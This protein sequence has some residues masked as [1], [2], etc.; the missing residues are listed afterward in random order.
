M[1]FNPVGKIGVLPTQLLKGGASTWVA[2]PP[3]PTR[4]LTA[5]EA[6]FLASAP[7]ATVTTSS[8][9]ST[10]AGGSPGAQFGPPGVGGQPVPTAVAG[11]VFGLTPLGLV[12]VGVPLAAS[13]YFAIKGQYLNAAL[14]AAGALGTFAVVR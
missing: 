9:T 8:G 4:Q 2:K 6:L 13:V 7:P 1:A 14:T 11:I 3:P 5:S 10:P 12:I